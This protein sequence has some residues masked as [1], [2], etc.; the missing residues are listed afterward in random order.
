MRLEEIHEDYTV[1]EFDA[2]NGLYELSTYEEAVEY[3]KKKKREAFYNGY[4]GVYYLID[5]P[6][7]VPDEDKVLQLAMETGN[8][9]P[10]DEILLDED[11]EYSDRSYADVELIIRTEIHKSYVEGQ[12]YAAEVIENGGTRLVKR[13]DATLDEKT[14]ETHFILHGTE[15]PVDGWFE[16]F[17]GRSKA[18]G[19]FGIPEEDCNCR[20]ILQ[21]R[22]K[23]G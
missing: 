14:R 19:Q 8:G 23:D 1:F 17:R 13:W 15:K 20:C 3:L 2:I 10:V 7:R 22:R 5:E 21:Y 16:T 4:M 11:G 18:P 9:V 12:E 6:F